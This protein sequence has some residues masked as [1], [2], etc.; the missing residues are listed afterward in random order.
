LEDD[1]ISS[2]NS[3]VDT[4][5]VCDG[6]FYNANIVLLSRQEGLNTSCSLLMSLKDY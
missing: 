2:Y 5:Q 4:L 1:F 6:E 3:G